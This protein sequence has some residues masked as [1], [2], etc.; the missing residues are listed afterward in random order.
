MPKVFDKKTD[1][2]EK[3]ARESQYAIL[4]KGKIKKQLKF[5]MNRSSC[6]DNKG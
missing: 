3:T 2:Q 5:E 4:L 6:T 1:E